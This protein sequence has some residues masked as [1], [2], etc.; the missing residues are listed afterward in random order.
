MYQ[1]YISIIIPVYNG[2]N[3]LQ[4]AIDSAWNQS[5][6]N[7]EIIVVNDGSCDDGR[8]QSIMDSYGD[9]IVSLTKT[10]GGVATALNYAIKH[11]M[12]EYFA[13]LSHDDLLKPDALELY[14]KNLQ[15]IDKETIVYGNYDLIDENAVSYQVI[16]FSKKMKVTE[17]ENSVY[18]VIRGCVNGCA[19]LIH[20]SHFQRVGM[21][22]EELKIT[23][24]NEMWFRIFRNQKVKY[25]KNVLCSK[26]YHAT[27][28]SVTKNVYPDEDK[29]I[30]GCLEQLSVREICGFV[31]NAGKFFY[32]IK[33][34][35]SD[36]R[37]PLTETYCN[38]MIDKCK[39]EEFYDDLGKNQL[40]EILVKSN[41]AYIEL[42]KKYE[43]L[44][45]K[46][47]EQLMLR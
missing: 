47:M 35:I 7:R 15:T 26:R 12:G 28:D 5:Y 31:G 44:Q 19:C 11:M 39:K 41:A 33:Q 2:S 25:I 46:Y 18:P 4:Q 9:K 8:T 23:Q 43:E 16:D 6:K 45:K 22:N 24:D 21:F 10:N 37:H 32:E 36:G 1:P 42:E 34:N 38:M 40:K 20:R 13:W 3:Y 14:V 29:F 17:L 30:L 27:Q